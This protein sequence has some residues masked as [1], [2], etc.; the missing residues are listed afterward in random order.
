[1]H[2]VDICVYLEDTWHQAWSSRIRITDV[3]VAVKEDVAFYL[4]PENPV[5]DRSDYISDT[6]LQIHIELSAVML[7]YACS[8]KR[9]ET[10]RC[11]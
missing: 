8:L 5:F 4:K 2:L 1:M 3:P 10:A 7:D 11:Y 9:P 6:V